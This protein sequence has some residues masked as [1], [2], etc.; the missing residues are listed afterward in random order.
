[1]TQ[2]L[3]HLQDKA[4]YSPKESCD[5]LLLILRINNESRLNGSGYHA[6]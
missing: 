5:Y 6:R 1:M 2:I 4:K 3:S